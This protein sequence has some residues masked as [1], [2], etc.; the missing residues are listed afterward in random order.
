MDSMSQSEN[1]SKIRPM[2]QEE[3]N[4]SEVREETNRFSFGMQIDGGMLYDAA[5]LYFM[6]KGH[7]PEF[8]CKAPDYE[9][10]L[11]VDGYTKRLWN[12]EEATYVWKASMMHGITLRKDKQ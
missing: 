5:K 10:E 11:I 4:R 2:T 1:Y 6:V 12:N 8:L 9:L 3:R 7:I